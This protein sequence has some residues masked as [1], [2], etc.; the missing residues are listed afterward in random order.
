MDTKGNVA[1]NSSNAIYS[2]QNSSG[3]RIQSI[4]ATIEYPLLQ[5]KEII[6]GVVSQSGLIQ[7]MS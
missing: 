7:I 1:S 5:G 3:V 6:Y 4:W 2:V